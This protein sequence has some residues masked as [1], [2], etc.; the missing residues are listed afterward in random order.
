M[1]VP[2]RSGS[3]M[4]A[5]PDI[6]R[7]E[8]M[9]V[10]VVTGGALVGGQLMP[11]SLSE[12]AAQTVGA[13]AAPLEVALRVNGT[14]HRLTLDPRTTLLD[15]LREH[16]HLTGSKKGC[17]LGQCG[18]CTVLLDGKRVKS[19][20]SLAA[21]VEAREITTIE[22]LAQGE[23]LHPLQTAFIERDAFQCGYC[24][25]GQIMAGV[26]CIAEGH[27]R[28]PQE[29]RDWMSGNLCRCGAYD[30]IVAAIRDAAAAPT[31]VGRD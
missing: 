25:P 27:A 30:H 5:G 2:S 4:I 6:T 18:A 8:L 12:A 22:G 9:E 1:E 28:S 10:A 13:A 3:R 26:A 23:R 16:L 7:R 17:G 21:L 29:I 19:C 31:S 20:L 11:G 24:T 14:E 15:A